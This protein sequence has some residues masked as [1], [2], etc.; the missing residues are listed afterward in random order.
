MHAERGAALTNEFCLS[1]LQIFVQQIVIFSIL[2]SFA[3]SERT[4]FVHI[5]LLSSD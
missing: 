1:V 5:T 3:D 4:V 2:F